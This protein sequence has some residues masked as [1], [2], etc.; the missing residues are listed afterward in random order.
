VPNKNKD[1]GDVLERAVELIQ[2]AILS[3]DPGVAGNKFSIEVNKIETVAGVRHELDVYVKTQTG[4]AY[5]SVFIFECKNWNKP[6]G[7]NEV[8]VLA[9]KVKVICASRGFL[10]AR[11]FTRDAEAQIKLDPRLRTVVC[12]DD[13]ISPIQVELLHI[14]H[15]PLSIQLLLKERG[16][17]PLAQPTILDWK[18]S[19]WQ[20]NG[21]V[22]DA[23]AYPRQFVDEMVAQDK[24]EHAA[25]YRE[26]SA[27]YRESCLKVDYEPGELL[28]DGR[29]MEYLVVT[30]KL[31]VQI[32]KQKLLSKFELSEQGR[33][34]FFEPIEHAGSGKQI[35][36]T[37]VQRI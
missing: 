11:E 8:I 30:V 19:V 4:S 3:A 27:H 32:H 37:I 23:S 14:I 25:R 10:V 29:D 34:F 24:K 20:V 7:K 6:V 36:V 22:I 2:R 21:E 17:P 18:T 9:E 33:V 15:D 13:F 1:K 28:V 16:V 12:R 5:E 26:E 35:E 31:W